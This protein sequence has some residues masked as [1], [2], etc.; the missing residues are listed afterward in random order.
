MFLSNGTNLF[1]L[2]TNIS[3]MASQ[4]NPISTF[5]WIIALL[6]LLFIITES[7]ADNQQYNF[8]TTSTRK[9]KTTNHW[10]EIIKTDF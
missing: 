7:V 9:L 5:D 8:Q 3:S 4:E 2:F 10:M 1:I 6:M